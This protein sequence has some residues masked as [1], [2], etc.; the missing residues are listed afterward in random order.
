VNSV[1]E[2]EMLQAK[3]IVPSSEHEVDILRQVLIGEQGTPAQ[4]N[5][6]KRIIKQNSTRRLIMTKMYMHLNATGHHERLEPRTTY[7]FP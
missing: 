6:L 5:T 3:P 7:L 1:L 4:K 2:T